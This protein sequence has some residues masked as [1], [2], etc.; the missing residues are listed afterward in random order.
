MVETKRV[1]VFLDPRA[2][3]GETAQERFPAAALTHHL[4]ASG[5]MVDMVS[6]R[7]DSAPTETGVQT[8][9]LRTVHLPVGPLPNGEEAEDSEL[10]PRLRDAFLRFMLAEGARYDLLHGTSWLSGWIAV[11]LAARLELGAVVTLTWSCLREQASPSTARARMCREVLA[12]AHRLIVPSL[13][14]HFVLTQKHRVDAE[15]LEVIPPGVDIDRF[16]PFDRYQAREAL[17]LSSA[18]FVAAY[19][20]P[21][22]ADADGASVDEAIRRTGERMGVTIAVLPVPGGDTA[23]STEERHLHYAAS[24]VVIATTRDESAERQSLEAM[25]CGR[26]VIGSAIDETSFALGE[27]VTGYL[28]PPREPEELAE[29]L[30]QM[31]TQ[32]KLRARMGHAARIWVERE[33]SWPMIAKRTAAVYNRVHPAP[34]SRVAR[35]ETLMWGG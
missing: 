2:E 30:E 14:A 17:G 13:R 19:T 3:S 7:R 24:D 21:T 12:H 35:T 20:A 31:L 32:P 9:S 6:R 11:D 27:C 22:L 23:T 34:E 29:R 33:Y 4:A 25:A 15:R 16:R 8:E 18:D 26:P 10:G 5:H 28:V 1:A